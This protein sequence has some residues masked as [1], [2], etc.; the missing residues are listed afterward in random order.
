[1]IRGGK[2]F[3][4]SQPAFSNDSKRLLVC[5][6]NTVSVFSTDTGLQVA[7]LEGHTSLVTSVIVVPASTPASMI[8]CYCWTTSLDGT[9]RYWDFSVPELLKTIDIQ[10][11]VHS[12]VIPSLLAHQSEKNES[13]SDTY[14]YISVEDTKTEQND[15]RNDLRGKI[16][17]CNLSKSHLVSGVILGESKRPEKITISST[18][19]YFGIL[20]KRKIRV[21]EAPEKNHKNVSYRKIK[22]SHTKNLSCIAFHPTDRIMAA[23]DATGRILVWRGFGDKTFSGN[24]SENEKVMNDEDDK[25]GV[26]GTEDADSCTTWHWH[27]SEV[28]VLSFSSDGAYLFSGGNEGVLVGWQLDTGKKKFLPRIGTPLLNYISSPDSSLSSVSCADNRIHILKMPRME[29][30]KSISGIKLPSALPD[31]FSGS[32]NDFVFDRTAGL[33]AVRTENYCIQ[34]YSLFD[35][36]EVSEVQVCERNHQPGDAV[37]MVLNLV[38]LSLEGSVM[39]TVETRMA[40]EGIGGFVTLK[41]WERGFQNNDFNLSTVIYEPHRDAGVSAVAFHPTRGMAVSASY[42]GDFKVWVS[43]NASQPN[44]KL[45]QRTRWACHAVGSY[46]NKPMTAA[47]FSNDGS[48]LAVAAETVITLWDPEK[49]FLVAVIGSTRES[50]E[51]LSFI[52]ASNF[53]VSASQGTDPQ[54][55]VWNMSTLSVSWSYKLHAEAIACSEKDSCFAVLVLVPDSSEADVDGAILL[56]NAGDPVSV[57]SWF[58]TKAKGGGIAFIQDRSLDDNMDENTDSVLLAYVNG[59][60]EYVVFNPHGVEIQAKKVRHTDNVPIPEATGQAGYASLYGNLLESK[61]P[62]IEASADAVVAPLERPWETIFSGPSH[63]LPPL[64]KLCSAFLD[65][66]LE[67]RNR[68]A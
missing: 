36:R 22:L 12:M 17:K 15:K 61:L 19:K 37:T 8:L 48:I 53:L 44:D 13:Q 45:S 52:G 7:E 6:G 23:G 33:V 3:V 25:P 4:S 59:D 42:G 35:D 20:E 66:F 63:S 29:I 56:F 31:M 34:F 51:K 43:N 1:M 67:K 64:T 11:P 58:V 54:L 57:A 2:S 18:G 21:W 32:C 60:H 14:A 24:N 9:I 5:T 50:I 65:S 55:S 16:L 47:A 46:R 49:N 68:G 26:R 39:S 41:F 40:E 62:A 27:S 28:K 10:L 30:L 38:A